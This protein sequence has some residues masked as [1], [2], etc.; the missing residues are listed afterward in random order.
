MRCAPFEALYGRKCRSPIMWAEVGEGQLIG[1]ELVQETTEKIPQIKDRL[2]A[3]RDRQKSYAD[4]RRKPLEFRVGEY[5]LLKVSP[6]KG[7]ARFGKKGK[8][9]PWF[10]GPF[11]ITERIGPVAYRLRLPEE[12]NGVHDTFHRGFFLE[13]EKGFLNSG[14]KKKAGEETS[15]SGVHDLASQIRKIDGKLLGD[16]VNVADGTNDVAMSKPH[17]L[18]GEPLKPILKNAKVTF[19]VDCSIAMNSGPNVKSNTNVNLV[20]QES[21]TLEYVAATS[22]NTPKHRSIAD[23][24][25]VK[26][27][28]IVKISH[29]TTFEEINGADVAIPK[30]NVDEVRVHFSNTLYGYFIGKRIPFLIVEKYVLNTRAKY[31]VERV[32]M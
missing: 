11:E 25:K 17:N 12:L 15:D 8:L 3:T 1:P 18:K 24:F 21:N 13:M 23:L 19:D 7:V 32:I 10:V 2:K 28:K 4:K 20:Q 16:R 6:W 30:A 27:K 5:V 31:D 14:S 22:N 26:N 9:A 29:I